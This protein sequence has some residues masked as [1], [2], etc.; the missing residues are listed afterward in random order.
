[1]RLPADS[2][3]HQIE[4]VLLQ[5]IPAF[6]AQ[7]EAKEPFRARRV[8]SVAQYRSGVACLRVDFPAFTESDSQIPPSPVEEQMILNPL[9]IGFFQDFCGLQHPVPAVL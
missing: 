9:I 2:G 3:L 1:L 8:G 7:Q 5:Q 4:P 6:G